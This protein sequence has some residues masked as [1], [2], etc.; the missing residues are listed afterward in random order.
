MGYST[1]FI[2]QFDLNRPLDSEHNSFLKLFANTR[3]GE[4]DEIDENNPEPPGIW[5]QWVP[6]EDG[7]TIE[8]DENEKFYDYIEWIQYLLKHF[9]IPWGYIL[10]GKVI[11]QGE[12]MCD[13]GKIE[14]DNNL[15]TITELE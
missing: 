7:K 8:W 10:N 9:L 14:I 15:V 13:R 1:D 3:H 5:C 4:G 2:G 6:S 11:W 12:N